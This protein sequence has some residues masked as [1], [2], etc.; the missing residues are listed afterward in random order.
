MLKQT[1]KA[2]IAGICSVL[3]LALFTACGAQAPQNAAQT[4]PPAAGT[5]APAKKANP[6]PVTLTMHFPSWKEY[7][8]EEARKEF[9]EPVKKKYPHITIETIRA[10]KGSNLTDLV[11]ASK[12]PDLYVTSSNVVT[13]VLDTEL[14]YPMDELIKANRLDLSDIRPVLLDAIRNTT[15]TDKLIAL[16]FVQNFS[17]LYYN[18]DIF[19]HFGVPYPKDGMNWD[20]AYELAKKL[21]RTDSGVHY[22]GLDLSSDPLRL[23]SQLSLP[24]LDPATAKALVTTDKWKQVLERVQKIYA[25][26]GN[27]PIKGDPDPF[28]KVKN[29]AMEASNNIIG[30][31]LAVPD[32]NWD[33]TTYPVWNEAPGTGMNVDV[34]VVGISATSK[35]KEDAFLVVQTLLSKDWQTNETKQG[36]LSVLNSKDV[37]QQFGSDLPVKGK[38]LQSVF[39]IAPAAVPAPTRYIGIAKDSMKNTWKAVVDGQKDI[40]TALRD[41]QEEIDKKIDA[42]KK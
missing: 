40:N 10:G 31:I 24:F 6:D 38:N 23:G 21:S 26:P 7:S 29:A 17:A 33:M 4:N 9:T 42:A 14:G 13:E 11:A 2:A 15:G 8:T 27:A 12:A 30:S 16:P 35:H 41:A 25:I 19:D 18:K 34:H 22:R 39:K 20:D 3:S 5:E 28:L 32:L 37:Q 1:K 36:R